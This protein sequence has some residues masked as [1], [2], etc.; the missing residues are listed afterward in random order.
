MN[1]PKAPTTIMRGATLSSREEQQNAEFMEDTRRRWA[2]RDAD[3]ALARSSVHGGFAGE[4][5]L[6]LGQPGTSAVAFVGY[7]IQNDEVQYMQLDVTMMMDDKGM[8]DMAFV[9]VCPGC[10]ALGYHPTQ[11]QVVVR[12]SNRKWNLDTKSQGEVFVDETD[13]RAY[14]LAGKVYCEEKCRCPRPNCGA[15]YR[16]GDWS[17]KDVWA[18][19]HTTKMWRV[20]LWSPSTSPPSRPL[21]RRRAS[22]TASPGTAYG[23]PRAC[24]S[25]RWAAA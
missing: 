10:I 19:P 4:K 16:F 25:G 13:G 3:S 5:V 24:P 11:A 8:P 21:P 12:N 23:P 18:R 15:V 7:C 20:K 2:E 14:T 22:P 1:E 17:P 9:F 6:D